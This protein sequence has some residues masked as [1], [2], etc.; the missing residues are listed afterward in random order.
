[1]IL[2]QLLEKHALKIGLNRFAAPEANLFRRDQ[3]ADRDH[4]IFDQA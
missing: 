1:M 3:I 2:A 4:D